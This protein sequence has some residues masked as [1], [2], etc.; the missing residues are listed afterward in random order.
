M[1]TA[2]EGRWVGGAGCQ[3]AAAYHGCCARSSPKRQNAPVA[4]ITA[5]ARRR[6]ES[7]RQP[8]VARMRHGH[9]HVLLQEPVPVGATFRS[10]PPPPTRPLRMRRVLRCA[11]GRTD[12][13]DQCG[14]TWG[15]AGLASPAPPNGRC[16]AQGRVDCFGMQAPPGGPQPRCALF[17][18][19]NARPELSCGGWNPGTLAGHLP[20]VG[21]DVDEDAR[22]AG[23][24]FSLWR[25][26]AAP[27][28]PSHDPVPVTNRSMSVRAPPLWSIDWDGCTSKLMLLV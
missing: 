20:Y 11:A 8:V 2:W 19:A 10:A 25:C 4:S 22:G 9:R 7:L 21:D 5:Q 14:R 26:S 15:R 13:R 17:A 23:K 28:Q 12:G 16:V 18:L 1:R 24:P 6:H 27:P 3:A